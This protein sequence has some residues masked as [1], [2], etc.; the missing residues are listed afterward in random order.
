[1]NAECQEI[2]ARGKL[3]LA[4]LDADE[5]PFGRY[6]CKDVKGPDGEYLDGSL[7]CANRCE[8]PPEG[9]KRHATGRNTYLFCA[10]AWAYGVRPLEEKEAAA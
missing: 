2:L 9:C 1:M 10:W 3:A 6:L 7:Y 5:C 4:D 8:L